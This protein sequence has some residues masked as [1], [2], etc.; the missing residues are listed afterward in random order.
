[1]FPTSVIRN[2]ARSE[3]MFAETHNFVGLTAHMKGPVD[4]DAMSAAFDA[5]IEAHPV[6]AGHLHELP[7]GRH[8]IVVD[9]LLHPGM[10]VVELDDADDEPPPILLDQASS[11]VQLRL[12]IRDGQ[13]E[14][15]LYI[16][17]CVADGHHQFSF[18][19]E[20]FG[21]YAALVGTGRLDPVNVE[22][23]PQSLE[24]VLAERGIG[25]QR[26]SGL[27]KFMPAMFAH[28]LPPT[29]RATT[30]A[31]PAL[32]MRVP[33]ARCRLSESETRQLIDYCR[34]HRLRTNAVFS[35]A[36]LMAE[37]Q[38]RETPHIPVPYIYPVDLRYFLSPPVSAT[39]CTNPLGVATYLAHID[40]D[41]HIADLARDIAETF[42]ADVSDGVVQ[43]SLLHFSPQYVGNPPG[44]PDVVMFTDNGLIP[45]I[46]TPDGVEFTACHS[47]M[48]FAVGAGIDMYSGGIFADQLFIEHHSHAPAPERSTDLIRNLLCSIADQRAATGVG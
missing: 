11:L 7:D 43:Q 30:D 35:A 39:G 24:D 31:R 1:M 3:E 13:P 18:V 48:Y 25:K 46:R 29:R 2:L 6:L 47:E 33:V 21:S 15:T 41:T 9:D 16:H 26:R 28:D 5:L 20:L 27:E 36:I 17:H 42:Q 45:D 44:L 12:T 40:N 4:I 23:A 38:L 14:P 37:W 10:E 19:E 32:P 8:Q 34:T 22:P